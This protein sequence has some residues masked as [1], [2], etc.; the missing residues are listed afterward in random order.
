MIPWFVTVA[1]FRATSCGITTDPMAITGSRFYSTC[2]CIIPS[3][4]APVAEV[5]AGCTTH[6]QSMRWVK[7]RLKHMD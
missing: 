3:C 6:K 4:S 1:L 5:A 7:Q 2:C